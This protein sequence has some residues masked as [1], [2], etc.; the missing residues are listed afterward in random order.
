MKKTKSWSIESYLISIFLHVIIII[1]LS[2]FTISQSE[3]IKELDL[4]WITTETP[5]VVQ[6]DFTPIGST[7]SRQDK[8]VGSSGYFK[9]YQT[10]DNP[11]SDNVSVKTRIGRSIEPPTAKPN[12]ETNSSPQ[13]GSGSSY[14]SGVKSRLGS[15]SSGSSGY[16]LDDDGGN[17]AVLKSVLPQAAI[18][19]YGLV[20]LQFKIKSDG[21]VDPESIIPVI[22]DDPIY[23]EASIKALK[24][25]RFSVKNQI[26]SKSYRISFIFK[27]E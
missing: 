23:T 18:S 10:G 2:L 19:D 6:E 20:K 25:W 12:A 5:D 14:L 24:M 13:P 21:S 27:P 9:D 16:Q 3:K 7:G 4:N 22:L 26:S 11:P 8:N 15:G 1:G 17:I